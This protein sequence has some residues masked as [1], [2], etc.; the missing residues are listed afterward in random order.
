M[1]VE[2]WDR[3]RAL[4]RRDRR[5]FAFISAVPHVGIQGKEATA[6][7]Q[8]LLIL[9]S[10]A[11]MGWTESLSPTHSPYHLRWMCFLLVSRWSW[12]VDMGYLPVA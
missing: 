2:H 6:P 3:I 11:Q 1:K 8:R 12:Q 5:E 4:I 7:Q 10:A 9:R